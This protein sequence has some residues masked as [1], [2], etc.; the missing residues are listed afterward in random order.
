MYGFIFFPALIVICIIVGWLINRFS[1]KTQST[2][3]LLLGI[4]LTVFGLFLLV[5]WKLT[6]ESVFLLQMLAV[7]FAIFGLMLSIF[8]AFRKN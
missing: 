8:S 2:D 1:K 4:E 7:V 5:F 6:L 3:L